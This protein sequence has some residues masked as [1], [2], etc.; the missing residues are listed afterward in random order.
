ML[1]PKNKVE[2]DP[3]EEVEVP[4]NVQKRR[5]NLATMWLET[6]QVCVHYIT[7]RK[8]VEH[9]RIFVSQN[10]TSL[11]RS[12]ARSLTHSLCKSLQILSQMQCK[13]AFPKSDK[14]GLLAYMHDTDAYECKKSLEICTKMVMFDTNQAIFSNQWQPDW[15]MWLT[16]PGVLLQ[17]VKIPGY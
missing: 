10:S 4:A 5:D 9:V 17:R 13:K 3:L 7:L 6:A 15:Q 12:L 1:N 2:C 16:L 14:T 11:T 8:P